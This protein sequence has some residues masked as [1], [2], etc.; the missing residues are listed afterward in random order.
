[1]LR[2]EASVEDNQNQNIEYVKKEDRFGYIKLI[3]RS[4]TDLGYIGYC[5]GID[6]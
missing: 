1:M 6:L 3:D 4:F 2:E 5:D